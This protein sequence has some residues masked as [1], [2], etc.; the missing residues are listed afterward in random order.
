[1]LL[2]P[3]GGSLVNPDKLARHGRL[4][5]LPIKAVLMMHLEDAEHVP[6]LEAFA[7]IP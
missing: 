4:F 2:E 1:M 5:A 6:S 3:V 7:H